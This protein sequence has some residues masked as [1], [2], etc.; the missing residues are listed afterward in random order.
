M[1]LVSREGPTDLLKTI[2][3]VDSPSKSNGTIES[4]FVP[5]V[6]SPASNADE[7][8]NVLIA[9]S[10]SVI[11]PKGDQSEL[12]SS[13]ALASSTSA[14]CS[15]SALVAGV[16]SEANSSPRPASEQLDLVPVS[17][18]VEQL[19][20]AETIGD[21]TNAKEQVEVTIN[22]DLINEPPVD[23]EK[24][25]VNES[26]ESF[27]T[28]N[29]EESKPVAQRA[30]RR[31]KN[32]RVVSTR[33]RRAPVVRAPAKRKEERNTTREETVNT[34]PEESPVISVAAAPSSSSNVRVSGR[35]IPLSLLQE[36]NLRL[37]LAR[38][39]ERTSTGRTRSFPYADDYVD[40]DDLEKQSSRARSTRKSAG[41]RV[42]LRQQPIDAVK[43]EGDVYE[44]MDTGND[45]KPTPKS[46]ARKRPSTTPTVTPLTNKKRSVYPS[47]IISL[48]RRDGVLVVQPLLKPH[49][50]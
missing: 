11:E 13:A 6:S 37:N 35:S 10:S 27:V 9:S 4:S 41:E 18:L 32:V 42:S 24:E 22:P 50:R 21:E 36:L 2:L 20:E 14:L 29:E 34:E 12:V 25:K 45:H 16:E 33:A 7:G 19:K 28:E 23:T 48:E 26:T 43:S 40:L 1:S 15:D 8:G 47:E 38:I 39:K 46:N 44:Q 30:G 3:S 49:Q 17:Q 5:H 31:K